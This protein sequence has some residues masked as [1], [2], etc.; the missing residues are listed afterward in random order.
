A[1]QVSG[2]IVAKG[3]EDTLLYRQ[4]RLLARCEVGSE[5]G[6]FGIEPGALH[7]QLA[8]GP[9]RSLLATSTHDT[10]RG[11]DVRMRIA[12]LSELPAVWEAAVGRWRARAERGWRGIE[13]DRTLEYA[14]WQTLVGAWPLPLERAQ[15]WAEKAARE[16]RLRTS[17]RRADAAY[18][19]ARTRWL[20]HVYADRELCAELEGFAAR[21]RPHGDRNSLAQLLV[22]LA[23]PG[24]PD[25]NQG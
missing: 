22:K 9:P 21:L 16:A 25:F 17:W 14:A 24:V 3:D 13:P 6:A 5:L 8:A 7:A 20:E 11:E 1:Q 19:A 23:A 10:K 12:V 2:S 15:R 18:E 4:V